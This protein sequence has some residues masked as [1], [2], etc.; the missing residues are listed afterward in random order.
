MNGIFRDGQLAP[1]VLE[2]I[3]KHTEGTE[4][5]T[6]RLTPCHYCGHNSIVVFEDARG[7]VQAK[8]KVCKGES[9]YNVVFCRNG[10]V[11]FILLN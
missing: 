5:M 11:R 8:C 2:K 7:H 3:R 6:S 1:E 10:R 9:V 4:N